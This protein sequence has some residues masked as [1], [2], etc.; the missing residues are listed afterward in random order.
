MELIYFGIRS[1]NNLS[2]FIIWR[3][4]NKKDTPCPQCV[5]TLPGNN[6]INN[7]NEILLKKSHKM[8]I[9]YAAQDS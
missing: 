4:N 1:F 3:Q 9:S 5:Y 2:M 6:L 8:A 7:F